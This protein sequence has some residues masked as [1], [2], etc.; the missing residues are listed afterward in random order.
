MKFANRGI[1][2][3]LSKFFYYGNIFMGSK[4]VCFACLIQ[5]FLKKVLDDFKNQLVAQGG[6]LVSGHPVMCLVLWNPA[7]NKANETLVHECKQ[8]SK[9]YFHQY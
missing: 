1:L 7:Q 3:N 6:P 2:F 8:I 5:F 9:Q 4:Y